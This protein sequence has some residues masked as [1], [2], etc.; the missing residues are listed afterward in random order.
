MYTNSIITLALGASIVSAS[1]IGQ[2]KSNTA[3][4][5]Q[6]PDVL[7]CPDNGGTKVTRDEVTKF[8]TGPKGELR[9]EHANNLATAHCTGEGFFSTIPLYVV[10]CVL[11]LRSC[12][13]MTDLGCFVVVRSSTSR[14]CHLLC[15]RS[16]DQVLLSLW[17]VFG[18]DRIGLARLMQGDQLLK[19][20]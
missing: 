6:F 12:F 14:R 7:D 19:V 8:I 1:A 15:L 11:R 4:Y 17:D 16:G 3:P 2:D 13:R 10:S 18:D 5:F 9:E 20:E